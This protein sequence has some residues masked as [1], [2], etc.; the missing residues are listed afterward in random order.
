MERALRILDRMVVQN[1][2]TDVALDFRY[3]D[4]ATDAFRCG[5]ACACTAGR[6]GSWPRCLQADVARRQSWN[7]GT[8]GG[9]GAC[10]SLCP[11]LCAPP[12]A[13]GLA[14]AACCHCGSSSVPRER[15]TSHPSRGR[16]RTA[17]CLRCARQAC[18]HLPRDAWTARSRA[19][20]VPVRRVRACTGP[21]ALRSKQSG[22][23]LSARAAAN[24][25]PRRSGTGRS[26]STARRAGW[27]RS[28]ASRTQRRRRTCSSRPQV[29]LGGAGGPGAACSCSQS[30]DGRS[31][32]IACDR[33][34]RQQ[35]A[36]RIR[37]HL[38]SDAAR[39][40][41]GG[42]LPPLQR[43]PAGHRLLRRK[44]RRL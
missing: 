26:T 42:A 10:R 14:R 11:R 8:C 21:A 9:L 33:S 41:N 29:L 4:D 17:T 28:T 22:K 12:P 16:P 6:L 13:P 32:R 20:A 1:S 43:Q 15:S 24:P 27:S 3:W 23:S 34:A 37:F 44:R 2:Y 30:G 36:G 35:A 39:R 31:Y 25:A 7:D 18:T 40:R 5:G 19:G 38:C